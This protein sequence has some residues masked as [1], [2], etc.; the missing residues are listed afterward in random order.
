M[1]HIG[2]TLA[3]LKLPALK[4]LPGAVL[5]AFTAAMALQASAQELPQDQE[6][7]YPAESNNP[8]ATRWGLGL[9][10]SVSKKVYAGSDTEVR[11]LP[12][13]MYDNRWVS[14]SGAGASLK[15]PSAGPFQFR[16]SVRYAE[17]YK[18]SDTAILNG[19]QDRKA[20]LWVGPQ[21]SLRS[22][23]GNLS[24]EWLGDAMSHSN[25]QQV[26]VA[27]DHDFRVGVFSIRPRIAVTWLDDNY[28]DYYYGVTQG[29]STS[30]RPA[31]TGK[32]STDPELGVRIAY[33]LAPRHTISLDASASHLGSGITNSPLVDRANHFS[34][35]LGY[36]Y[37]F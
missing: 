9:G 2:K 35:R 7:F 20:S 13:L 23:A 29:E 17:G 26:R 33:P 31:Y 12:L 8:D 18:A 34:V 5:G 37:N 36:L 10:A 25:G 21:A 4:L 16:L 1:L 22:S 11:A 6:Q 24:A 14:V 3:A 28:V 19:M 15:L 27:F 30:T 32:A